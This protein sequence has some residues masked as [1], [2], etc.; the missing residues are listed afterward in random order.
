MTKT[1]TYLSEE[2]KN[3]FLALSESDQRTLKMIHE[4]EAHALN[5]VMN[6]RVD[7]LIKPSE[8]I[9]IA[10]VCLESSDFGAP[11]PEEIEKLGLVEL[12]DGDEANA[13]VPQYGVHIISDYDE[14]KR[15][16]PHYAHLKR[17]EAE[18]KNLFPYIY[19]GYNKLARNLMLAHRNKREPNDAEWKKLKEYAK[20]NGNNTLI[21]AMNA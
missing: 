2:A 9:T 13:K 15:A 21:Q 16:F 10:E 5:D 19:C 11:T 12:K 6:S 20:E 7:A 14:F 1:H 8:S 18:A 3:G 17:K 4:T